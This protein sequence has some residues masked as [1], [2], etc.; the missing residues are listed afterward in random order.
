MDKQA[1]EAKEMVKNMT[2]KEK[3]S[4]FWSYYKIHTIVTLVIL[5]LIGVTIY[6]IASK[7]EYDLEI[8]FYGTR[9]VSE[10]Q[11][12]A[13][14][15]YLKDYVD[16]ID[17][18]GEK[19]VKLIRTGSLSEMGAAGYGNMKFTAELAA[20]QYTIYILNEEL[21]DSFSKNDNEMFS[22]SFDIRENSKCVELLGMTETD[23]PT[24]WC[25]VKLPESI[26]DKPESKLKMQN[27]EN[28][29]NAILN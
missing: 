6:Q 7:K 8:Q 13:L 15:D 27:A 5:G 29:T 4:H 18:D 3:F 20:G 28:A 25:I 19:T 22:Q 1:R 16:D 10:E 12:A 2:I 17:G 23:E 11:A 9:M 21:Y 14:E 26:Q 24:Y